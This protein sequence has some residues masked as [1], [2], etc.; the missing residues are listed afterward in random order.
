MFGGAVLL[1][2]KRGAGVALRST[3]NTDAASKGLGEHAIT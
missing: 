1:F 3:Q 2:V